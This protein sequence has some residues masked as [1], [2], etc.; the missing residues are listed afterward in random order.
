VAIVFALVLVALAI[1][2][3]YG[4][5]A[6]QPHTRFTRL[7]PDGWQSNQGA[8]TANIKGA[9]LGPDAG[10]AVLFAI[11]ESDEDLQYVGRIAVTKGRK[12]LFLVQSDSDPLSYNN[13]ALELSS[14]GLDLYGE[15]G[16]KGTLK[17]VA[18][19]LVFKNAAGL[20]TTIVP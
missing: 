2:P 5:W 1:D 19:G 7:A 10:A 12:M 14:E 3:G 9:N 17:I 15:D 13:V 6:N 18:G 16:T 4:G 8:I 11:Q 20:E